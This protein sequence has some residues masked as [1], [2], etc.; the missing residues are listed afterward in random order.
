M[1]LDDHD[2][3]YILRENNKRNRFSVVF[4]LSCVIN[5]PRAINVLSIYISL[6][7]LLTQTTSLCHESNEL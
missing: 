2:H 7:F 6:I 3:Q 1:L 4:S 5:R